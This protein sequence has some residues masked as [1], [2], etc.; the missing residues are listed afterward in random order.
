MEKHND[1]ANLEKMEHTHK[2]CAFPQDDESTAFSSTSVYWRR[3]ASKDAAVEET[4]NVESS[5]KEQAIDGVAEK[6]EET[7][8]H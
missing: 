3:S 1:L 2:K 4:D 8:T 6:A 5:R 7:R